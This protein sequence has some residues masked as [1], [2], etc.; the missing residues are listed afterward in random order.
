MLCEVRRKQVLIPGHN[1]GPSEIAA[2]SVWI[3]SRLFPGVPLHFSA[4]HP[5]WK[6]R[7]VSATPAAT[8]SR[9]REIAMSAGL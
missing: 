1:D 2:L 3:V 8:L 9:A 6:M 7:D 5:D 4:F